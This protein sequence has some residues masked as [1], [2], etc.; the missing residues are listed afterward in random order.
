M[1][2]LL[3]I[4]LLILTGC[5]VIKVPVP[6][7][8]P[9]GQLKGY[10]HATTTSFATDR[11][12]KRMTIKYDGMEITVEGYESEQIEAFKAGLDFGTKAAKATV[13]P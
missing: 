4:T 3:P 2:T 8:S 11:R 12:I 5:T 7:F 13:V 1:K 6:V 10:T 9:S